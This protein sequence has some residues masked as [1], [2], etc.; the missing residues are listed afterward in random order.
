M[1]IFT[2]ALDSYHDA[3]GN[4]YVPPPD[5]LDL[6][7]Q[8]E[9]PMEMQYSILKG[10][11]ICWYRVIA[12]ECLVLI[13]LGHLQFVIITTTVMIFIVTPPNEFYESVVL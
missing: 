12:Y 11:P 9:E 13:L 10:N 3:P 6:A 4:E 2:L 7:T 5:T 1:A 8:T